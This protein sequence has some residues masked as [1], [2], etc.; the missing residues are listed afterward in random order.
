MVKL[1]RAVFE[2]CERQRSLQTDRHTHHNMCL[3]LSTTVGL[4][5]LVPD[6]LISSGVHSAGDLSSNLALATRAL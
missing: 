5:V 4:A 6:W 1:G 3:L 2:L